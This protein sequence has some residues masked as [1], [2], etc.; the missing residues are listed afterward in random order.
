MGLIVPLWK[1]KGDEPDP[2]KYRGIT[3][4]S[5]VLEDQVNSRM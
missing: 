1:R 4:F 3:L 5:Q 2:E